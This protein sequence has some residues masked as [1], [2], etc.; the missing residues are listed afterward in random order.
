[1]TKP[2]ILRRGQEPWETTFAAMRAFTDARTADSPDQLWIVEHPP[3]YTLG[4]GADP[5]HVLDAHDI[6][7]LQADRGGEVT[8][9]GPGQAVVYLLYDLRR[10][11]PQRAPA[12]LP[13][14]FVRQVEQAVID[15]LASY[16]L[17][18]VRKEGAPGIYVASGPRAGAKI[19]A[20]G[21]KVRASGCTY[22]GVALNVNMDLAPFGWINPCGYAGMETVDMKV[23]GVDAPLAEVQERLAANLTERLR[24]QAAAGPQA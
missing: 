6:P 7:V 16:N 14:E 23:M 10:A 4:L 9:H 19:A 22:H 21:L 3:V 8:Y 2:E 24:G 12:L 5:S 13:K 11:G 18:G 20:L 17:T 15:T 1:M